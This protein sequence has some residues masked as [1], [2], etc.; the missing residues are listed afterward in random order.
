MTNILVTEH[1]ETASLMPQTV[2]SELQ[3]LLSTVAVGADSTPGKEAVLSS[4]DAAA[5]VPLVPDFDT[6][7]L[8]KIRLHMRRKPQLVELAKVIDLETVVESPASDAALTLRDYLFTTTWSQLLDAARGLSDDPEAV[9][10]LAVR[11]KLIGTIV[12]GKEKRALAIREDSIN[13][14]Q[15]Q[16]RVA[17]GMGTILDTTELLQVDPADAIAQNL[18]MSELIK[19]ARRLKST[20]QQPT[21]REFATP[22]QQPEKVEKVKTRPIGANDAQQ[23]EPLQTTERVQNKPVKELLTLDLP[24]MSGIPGY[25]ARRYTDV[26]DVKV[27]RALRPNLAVLSTALAEGQPVNE[28][29]MNKYSLVVHELAKKIAANIMPFSN[30]NGMLA[31][32][33]NDKDKREEYKGIPIWF[34]FDKSPNA[35][36]VYFTLQRDGKNDAGQD[37]WVMIVLGVTDMQNQLEFFTTISKLSI[38][39]LRN[40]G[41]GA[42]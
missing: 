24:W 39:Q 42:V 7:L 8:E 38:K 25:Q 31:V 26:N 21:R 19:M 36:R 11:S 13:R 28:D 6:S 10:P 5:A 20:G 35:P 3:S 15:R 40:R 18:P 14:E 1:A 17:S 22:D 30:A 32:K 29:G 23:Q 12:L 16:R 33:M 4:L 2:H 27:V 37:S 34:N 41:A 9:A